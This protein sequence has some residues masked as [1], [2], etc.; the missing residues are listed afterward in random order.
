MTSSAKPGLEV[1]AAL[2]LSL[3]QLKRWMK[4]DRINAILLHWQA[5][6]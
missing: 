6:L 4:N 3:G 1:K 2:R 5:S